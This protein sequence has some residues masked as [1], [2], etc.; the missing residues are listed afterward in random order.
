MGKKSVAT[1]I[2]AADDEG[3]FVLGSNRSCFIYGHNRGLGPQP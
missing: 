2:L 3:Q 1:S